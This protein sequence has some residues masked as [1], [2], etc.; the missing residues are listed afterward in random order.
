MYQ[1]KTDVTTQADRSG[2]AQPSSRQAIQKSLRGTSYAEGAA[3]LKP[4][5]TLKAKKKAG[6]V[7][8]VGTGARRTYVPKKP[9]GKTL[10]FFFG[11]KGNKKD[12]GIRDDLDNSI[13]DD[14]ASAVL[15]GFTV[16]YDRAGT[17]ADFLAALYDS[18]C[19]GLYW[20]G[21]GYMDGTIQS[22]AGAKI[23]PSDIDKTKVSSNIQ[24]LILVACGSGVAAKAWKAAVGAQCRFQGWVKAVNLNQVKDFNTDSILDK[25]VGHTGTD[26]SMELDDYIAVAA[27]AKK[28]TK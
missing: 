18:N 1:P 26:E 6:A 3:Q 14:I 4:D 13:E 24:Y 10:Y 17:K 16:T 25:Y 12:L 8:V 11:L 15:Q 27:R 20:C 28:K 21:H 2:A 5:D 7:T 22:S 19:F 23:R 9:N